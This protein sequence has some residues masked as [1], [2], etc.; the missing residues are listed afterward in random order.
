MKRPQKWRMMAAGILLALWC[1][2]GTVD[3][4][5]ATRPA[6]TAELAQQDAKFI[7]A[8]AIF[9]VRHAEFVGHTNR[10]IHKMMNTPLDRSGTDRAMELS[11]VLKNAGITHIITS[12]SLRTQ[13][14]ASYIAHELQIGKRDEV[15]HEGPNRLEPPD[16]VNKIQN[17]LAKAKSN[18]VFL[19]VYH[20]TVIPAI[21]DKLGFDTNH[22]G[23]KAEIEDEEF[24]RIYCVIPEAPPKKSRIMLLRYGETSPSGSVT[25]QP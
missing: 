7:N 21:L 5:Q 19:I 8:K 14:T 13:A 23:F 4:Q 25:R 17:Y 20:H 2:T 9:I 16:Q 11:H 18:D 22:L 6:S 12:T 24:D 3:A 10:V 15:D 1:A